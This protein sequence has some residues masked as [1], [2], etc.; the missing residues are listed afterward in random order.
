MVNLSNHE[1]SPLRQAHGEGLFILGMNAIGDIARFDGRT[2]SDAEVE[3]HI[4]ALLQVLMT[5]RPLRNPNLREARRAFDANRMDI[6]EPLLRE[7]LN[8]H[9]RD[10]DAMYLHA[11]CLLR[12][13]LKAAEEAKQP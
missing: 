7:F 9:P 8:K 4:A 11:Q 13:E 10:P 5:R 1:A 3:A 12:R 6:A 2:A